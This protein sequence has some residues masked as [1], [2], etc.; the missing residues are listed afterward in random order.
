M[1]SDTTK[2]EKM[3]KLF[4]L[5]L[6]LPL[7]VAASGWSG[8]RDIEMLHGRE[9]ARDKGFEI[10]FKT[11]HKNPDNCTSSRTVDLDCDNVGHNTQVSMALTALSTGKPI[12][13]WVDGCDSEGH[14]KAI[15]ITLR[16]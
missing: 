14:A 10:T 13:V 5:G 12:D 15:S 4:I 3:K 7:E 11:D 2:R 16:P 6:I 1:K 9:C 8:I